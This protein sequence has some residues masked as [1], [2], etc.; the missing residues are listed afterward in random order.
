[1][2]TVKIDV[3]IWGIG[4]TEFVFRLASGERDRL[5]I[6]DKLVPSQ[7]NVAVEGLNRKLKD[8]GKLRL[9]NI[10]R[11]LTGKDRGVVGKF[12]IVSTPEMRS[13]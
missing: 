5:G 13:R 8:L 7:L 1:M 2:K 3:G 10:P 4:E 12:K 11:L 9:Q 6:C